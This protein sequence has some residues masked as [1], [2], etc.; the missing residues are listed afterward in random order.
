MSYYYAIFKKLG[1]F[2]IRNE[3]RIY[4]NDASHKYEKGKCLG[5][6]YLKNPGSAL[7]D[8]NIYNDYH[9]LSLNKDKALPYIS[10]ILIKLFKSFP[11]R[12][13]RDDYFQIV[14]LFPVV[15]NDLGEAFTNFTNLKYD[16]NNTIEKL[17][18][19]TNF[20]Y[21]GW[22]SEPQLDEL[23]RYHLK[24]IVFPINSNL[25]YIEYCK[26]KY[27]KIFYGI[28]SISSKPKHLQGLPKRI[29]EPILEKYLTIF[30]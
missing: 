4:S 22:G 5:Y 11:M 1:D 12:F 23:R 17:K 21:F 2:V 24:N 13:D 26:N 3:T 25:F 19:G 7:P 30:K 14:N 10:N 18:D 27:E 15:G 20:V 29:I 16:L 9:P 8:N 6:F 28:P